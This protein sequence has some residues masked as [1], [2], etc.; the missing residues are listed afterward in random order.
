MMISR[1]SMTSTRG[2]TLISDLTPEEPGPPT[3]IDIVGTP[4][5]AHGPRTA[6]VARRPRERRRA[7]RGVKL[8]GL[9]DEVVDEL[10]RRVVHLDVEVLEAAGQVVVEPDRRNRDEQS[11]RRLDERFGKDRKST[12]LTP[13]TVKSRMPSSA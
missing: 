9:L 3:L 13:V 5:T 2:V 7:K 8:R 4:V 6:R 1:T 11:E 10:R 12:R